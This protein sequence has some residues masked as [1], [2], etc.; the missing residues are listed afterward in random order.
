MA[1]QNKFATVDLEWA[2]TQLKTWK[3]YVDANPFEEMEDRV[4]WKQTKGG[5]EMPIVIASIEAQQKNIR[6]MIKDYLSLLEV[7]KR[8]RL[9]SADKEA[10]TYGGTKTSPRMKAN[11]GKQDED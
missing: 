9:D 10:D 2:E 7:V 4:K 3:A 11:E 8:L 5:G 6:D 1:L